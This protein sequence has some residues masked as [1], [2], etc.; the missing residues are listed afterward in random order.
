MVHCGFGGRNTSSIFTPM[1]EYTFTN[2]VYAP[3]DSILN[4]RQDNFG[5]PV[6]SRLAILSILPDIGYLPK[7]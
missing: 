3:E 6:G 1:A 4:Y 5:I 7:V 2:Y